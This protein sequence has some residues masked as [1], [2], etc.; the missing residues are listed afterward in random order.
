MGINHQIWYRARYI[1][2]MVPGYVPTLPYHPYTT[3]YT[4]GYTILLPYM[5]A[6]AR[7]T[8]TLP[9]DDTLGSRRRNS[10]GERLYSLCFSKG[11]RGEGPLCAESSALPKEKSRK[12]G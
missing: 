12:I 9:D 2:T 8:T 1:P 3:L 6:L 11:V 4:P 10:L 5:P 7:C